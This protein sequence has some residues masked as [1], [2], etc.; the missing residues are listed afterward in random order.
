MKVVAAMIYGVSVLALC[1]FLG[2]LLGEIIGALL[3]INADIGGVG[4]A[5]VLLLL[6][7]ASKQYK[8]LDKKADQGI[9]FWKEMFIPVV[10]A[11]AA[12]QNVYQALS[13]GIYAIL[14]GLLAVALA[15]AL[16]PVLNMLFSK[17]QKNDAG[18]END[19]EAVC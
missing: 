12:S 2:K 7:T 19:N 6:V 9:G 16:L 1:M 13:G 15:F 11:M 5:M 8:K 4:F 10:I 17:N 18:K 3:G 14:A